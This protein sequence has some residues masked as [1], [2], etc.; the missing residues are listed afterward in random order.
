MSVDFYDVAREIMENNGVDEGLLR[1]RLEEGQESAPY[2]DMAMGYLASPPEEFYPEVL[3]ALLDTI[4]DDEEEQ[5]RL[6]LAFY[7]DGRE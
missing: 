1:R 2:T 5:K 4:T 6:V 7:S 3:R